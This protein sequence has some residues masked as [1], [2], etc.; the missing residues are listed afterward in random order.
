MTAREHPPAFMFYPDDFASDGVVEAMTTEEVGAYTLILCKAWRE[1]PPGTIPSD[2]R[3]LARWARLS[4]R[5]WANC[6]SAVLAAFK[7]GNDGRLHQ[8]RMMAEFQA[9]A[10][11]KETRSKAGKQGA[12]KR[13]QSHSPGI[14]EPC[15]SDSS[16]NVLPLAKDSIAFASAFAIK[17]SSSG[18][19]PPPP[20]FGGDIHQNI[21]AFLDAWN[22]NQYTR[23]VDQFGL[24][25]RLLNERFGDP[26]WVERWPEAL[27]KLPLPAFSAG[28]KTIEAGWFLEED[29]VPAILR[30]KYDFKPNQN[31]RNQ[32][33]QNPRPSDL[34]R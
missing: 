30:G 33:A 31:Q 17:G 11:Y 16:A 29:T 13:W 10:E 14:A 25:P 2:D 7:A 28:D 27:A 24:P 12:E 18:S 19:K 8:R 5:K 9:L 4:A 22:A 15:S 23:K 21:Q 34:L 20:D 6:K 1:N 3:I 26:V 32:P